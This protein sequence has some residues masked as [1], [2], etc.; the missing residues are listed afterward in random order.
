MDDK[1]RPFPV[2]NTDDDD[3]VDMVLD[4]GTELHCSVIAIF[5]VEGQQY[6]ALL[7][8]KL[9]EGYEEDDVFLYRYT[10]KGDDNIELGMI[11]SEEEYEIIADAFDELLDNEAYEDM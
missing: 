8:D 6:I 9:I 7:P 2:D 4:D 5:P 11:D 3:Y 10:D 1:N